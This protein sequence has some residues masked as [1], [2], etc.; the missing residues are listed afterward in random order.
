MRKLF[1]L[2]IGVL[3]CA[4]LRAC[5]T[6][7]R[8]PNNKYEYLYKLIKEDYGIELTEYNVV[9]TV[10][11]PHISRDFDCVASIKLS[12]EYAHVLKENIRDDASWLPACRAED[13]ITEYIDPFLNGYENL[14]ALRDCYMKDDSYIKLTVFED[15]RPYSIEFSVIVVNISDAEL[16]YFTWR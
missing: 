14:E 3:L 6:S 7:D 12:D 13:I 2:V 1:A 4:S 16:F 15:K 5:I 8:N 9:D 10:Y 11:E